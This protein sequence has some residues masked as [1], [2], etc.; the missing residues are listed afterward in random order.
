MKYYDIDSEA[1]WLILDQMEE[2]LSPTDRFIF[3]SFRKGVS[4]R[5]VAELLGINRQ[6]LYEK[7]YY[8]K[9]RIR[10]KYRELDLPRELGIL[11]LL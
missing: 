6:R 9:K 4:R 5:E 8:I 7:W 1:V 2:V 11:E 3:S 10:K